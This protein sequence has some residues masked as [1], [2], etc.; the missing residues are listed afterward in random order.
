MIDS[1]SDR[2]KSFC[3]SGLPSGPFL[4]RWLSWRS[5][6]YRSSGHAG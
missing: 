6:C 4:P 5:E 3:R 1:L 2:T